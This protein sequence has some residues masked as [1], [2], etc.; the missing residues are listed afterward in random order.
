MQFIA[1]NDKVLK[2]NYDGI[3][4]QTKTALTK[5]YNSTSHKSATVV[6]E[7]GVKKSK[8]ST[9]AVD[10]MDLINED[11]EIVDAPAEEENDNEEDI[12][13]LRAE[14]NKQLKSKTSKKSSKEATAK[15]Q[16]AKKKK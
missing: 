4:T 15:V 12:E 11:G 2:D 3:D 10:E 5:Y 14:L 9:S 16:P 7:I 1:E 8:K 13:A 6:Q